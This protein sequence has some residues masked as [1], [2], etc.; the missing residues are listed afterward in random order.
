[1]ECEILDAENYGHGYT[2]YIVENN[3]KD[4]LKLRSYLPNT[5]Y[6]T[7]EKVEYYDSD[8]IVQYAVPRGFIVGKS[9]PSWYNLCLAPYSND[10]LYLCQVKAKK[11]KNIWYQVEYLKKSEKLRQYLE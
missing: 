7:S 2:Q 10:I 11:H 3:T 9:P 1:M 6:I 8:V 5:I 4:T